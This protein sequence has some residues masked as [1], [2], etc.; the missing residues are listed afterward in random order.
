MSDLKIN[1][2]LD[3][4]RELELTI[5]GQCI[6]ETHRIEEEMDFY[7][8]PV[9]NAPNRT[10]PDEATCNTW[11]AMHFLDDTYKDYIRLVRAGARTLANLNLQVKTEDLKT[12][13]EFGWGA[14]GEFELFLS[15]VFTVR[16][17][18]YQCWNAWYG[19]FLVPHKVS[20]SGIF[21]LFKDLE[22]ERCPLFLDLVSIAGEMA[23]ISR[24]R[25]TI[26]HQHSL[27][28][29][30]IGLKYI[31]IH[32]DDNLNVVGYSPGKT[33]GQIETRVMVDAVNK[34]IRT[35]GRLLERMV[36]ATKNRAQPYPQLG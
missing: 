26:T 21:R 34:G 17:K 22:R 36:Q 29:L 18:V 23:D 14:R 28:A 20:E 10:P 27:D 35:T 5:F 7:C 15:R 9:F 6:R 11:N 1:D 12:S 3:R 8:P 24:L 30:G 33:P 19:S 4:I 31:E 16:D 2:E 13:I 32:R 25:N